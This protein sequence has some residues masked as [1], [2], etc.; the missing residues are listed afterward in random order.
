M[1]KLLS[2]ALCLCPLALFACGQAELKP[3]IA[4]TVAT[5]AVTTTA[6]PATTTEAP[7]MP[8]P[9][10]CP[11]AYRDAPKEYW[12]ILDNL[13]AFV[14]LSRQGYEDLALASFDK[15][16]I[17]TMSVY[18]NPEDIGYAIADINR[19]GT[20]ELLILY[21]DSPMLLSLY[22]LKDNC[23]VYLL[24]DWGSSSHGQFTM[25]GTLRFQHS[26]MGGMFLSSLRLE[27]GAN[28][29]T[30]FESYF[31]RFMY[32]EY[33][34]EYK[35]ADGEGER[36][37]TDQEYKDLYEQYCNPSNPMKFNFIPIEQ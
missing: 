29:L 37:F 22:T 31:F 7:T 24:G 4:T 30:E 25:D 32:D 27:P 18:H 34:M 12:P 15:I 11:A 36:P 10:E 3:E 35:N 17:H 23:P 5:Q 8:P 26:S 33:I 21:K 6:A 13:Y 14:Y 28:K 19:D 20:P 9:I 2:L 1:K 16:G